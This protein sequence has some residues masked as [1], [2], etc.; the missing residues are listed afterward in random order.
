VTYEAW[1]S[2]CDKVTVHSLGSCLRCQP[3]GE[4]Q[5]GGRFGRQGQEPSPSHEPEQ[6]SQGEGSEQSALRR[7]ATQGR[8]PDLGRCSRA[9][10]APPHAHVTSRE[11]STRRCAE[12]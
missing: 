12:C 3:R 10:A 1:C 8:P 7:S 5:G 11:L 4:S 9:V 6:L 2:R